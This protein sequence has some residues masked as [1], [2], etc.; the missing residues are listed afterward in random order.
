MWHIIDYIQLKL[1]GYKSIGHVRYKNESLAPKEWKISIWEKIKNNDLLTPVNI[2]H[3]E[4]YKEIKIFI[5]GKVIIIAINIFLLSFSYSFIKDS[6]TIA[7]AQIALSNADNV[8]FKKQIPEQFLN[9][10]KA[11]KKNIKSYQEI[12]LMEQFFQY[13]ENK[14]KSDYINNNSELIKSNALSFANNLLMIY[15]ISKWYWK[16]K[17]NQ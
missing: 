12:I 16:K 9:I 15:L 1:K 5:K 2:N 14:A 13:I 3:S 7:K 4:N 17:R 8:D 10:Y 11:K 6:Y